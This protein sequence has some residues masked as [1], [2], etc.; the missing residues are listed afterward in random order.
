LRNTLD[1]QRENL[2]VIPDQNPQNVSKRKDNVSGYKGVS[3]HK[4]TGKWQARIRVKG[5]SRCLGFFPSAQSAALVYDAA[6]IEHHGEFA[7]TNLSL[8]LI[9]KPVASVIPIEMAAAWVLG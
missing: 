9:K 2:R 8:G 3:F 6:A 1:N 7:A 4:G 5:D